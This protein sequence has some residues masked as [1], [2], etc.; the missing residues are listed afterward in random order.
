MKARAAQRWF[1][2][3]AGAA[4]EDIISPGNA[5][6]GPWVTA[7]WRPTYRAVDAG[8]LVIAEEEALRTAALIAAH[9][10][11]TLLLTAA[12]VEYTLIHI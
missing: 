4:A 11:D 8:V 9:G 7:G 3:Y 5:E 6:A 1:Q 12:I 10:V 2:I